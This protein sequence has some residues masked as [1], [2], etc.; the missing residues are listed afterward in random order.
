M[1][2]SIIFAQPEYRALLDHLFL[3]SSVEQGAF[4]LAG[5]AETDT[6]QKLLVREVIPLIADDFE[7]QRDNQLVIKPAALAWGMKRAA[8]EHLSLVLVHTHPR[9]RGHVEFSS[10]DDAGESEIF[11]NVSRRV[12]PRPHASVVVG[13]DDITGRIWADATATP[14]DRI[15]VVGPMVSVSSRA[16][17][18]NDSQRYDRQLRAFGRKGQEDLACLT[19]GIVGC[20]GT[21]SI[22]AE[23]LLRLG[24]GHVVAVDPD[25]VEDSNVTRVYGSTTRDVFGRIPKVSIVERLAME[26]GR[27]DAVTAIVGDVRDET[28]ARQLLA[29]DILFGCTDSHWS[30]LVLNKLA[31]QYLMPLI[32]MGTRI[33][34]RDGHIRSAGGRVSVILPWSPCLLCAGVVR[35]EVLAAEALPREERERL[36]EE[37]YVQG[38]DERAPSVISLNSTVASLAVTE[39][40]RMA[41]GWGDGTSAPHLIYNAIERTV[42]LAEYASAPTC[43]C[44]VRYDYARGDG[45]GLP[46]RPRR[47]YVA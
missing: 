28:I 18:L 6:V 24:V 38:V 29:V 11:S 26:I 45:N 12:G 37:G 21:G 31:V 44:H 27:P 14:A 5:V 43:W 17:A 42:R 47:D 13:P 19:A 22:V 36:R 41:T 40:L 16:R 9:S 15:V 1:N 39:F 46:Y 33:D 25:I 2:R 30:R 8:I 34:A 35:P 20:G 23:Q 4:L 32:D 10:V 3:D 7:V